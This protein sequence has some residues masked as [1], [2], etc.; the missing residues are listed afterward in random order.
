MIGRPRNLLP[1]DALTPLQTS[2]ILGLNTLVEATG[3]VI[4]CPRCLRDGF[5]MVD[6]DNDPHAPVW[7]M[8]CQ[9]CERRMDTATVTRALDADGD[10][11][12]NAEQILAP[13][14]LTVRCPEKKCIQH[15]LEIERRTD[16]TVIRCR[17]AKTTL[18]IQRP[19]VH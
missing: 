1:R 3:L 11:M 9:C 6:T 5:G 7:K 12:A 18:R 16:A 4:L 19:L 10:L 8:D 13:L 14:S 17:C 15:P 2:A